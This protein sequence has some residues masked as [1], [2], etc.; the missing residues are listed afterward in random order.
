[1]NS[2][3]QISMAITNCRNRLLSFLELKMRY[4]EDWPLIRRQ[5]LRAFGDMGLEGIIADILTEKS[6]E[7]KYERR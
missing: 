3:E 7:V 6:K 2:N 4:D 5:I 1:M